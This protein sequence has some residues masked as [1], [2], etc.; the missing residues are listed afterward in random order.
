MTSSE[1]E[2]SARAFYVSIS[3]YN[4]DL[5][6]ALDHVLVEGW[7]V[8]DV[9]EAFQAAVIDQFRKS[10]RELL[11]EKDL[12]SLS[13]NRI[14][15]IKQGYVPIKVPND[16]TRMWSYVIFIDYNSLNR[17]IDN[18]GE[19]NE[20]LNDPTE[21]RTTLYNTIFK[22]MNDRYLG[23]LDA[24]TFDSKNILDYQRMILG[25]ED[26]GIKIDWPIEPF[27]MKELLD[28]KKVKDGEVQQFAERIA[29]TLPL[30]KKIRDDTKY[31][32]KFER[33]ETKYYWLPL[34]W[35]I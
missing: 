15:T 27:K 32:F 20:K 16:N 9:P 30:L 14:R 23:Q 2:K 35:T 31:E 5:I 11:D 10:A 18:L 1:L 28:K 21:L 12:A 4:K 8:D 6:A 34:D 7:S 25:I 3:A 13:F 29:G 24:R 22:Q 19:L 17:A 26:Q 33:N